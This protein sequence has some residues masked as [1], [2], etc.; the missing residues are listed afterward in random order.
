LPTG[1]LTPSPTITS[2]STSVPTSTPTSTAVGTIP[3]QVCKTNPRHRFY[4]TPTPGP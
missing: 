4:C 2:T 3:P 1:S